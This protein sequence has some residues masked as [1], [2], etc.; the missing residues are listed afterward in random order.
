MDA[1]TVK[2]KKAKMGKKK[3]KKKKMQMCMVGD[4]TESLVHRLAASITEKMAADSRES[5]PPHTH[6]I[7]TSRPTLSKLNH[8]NH[9]F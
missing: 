6:Y 1:K 4:V 5:Q 9:H 2:K 8:P 3:R 7:T